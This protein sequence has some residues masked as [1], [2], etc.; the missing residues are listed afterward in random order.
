MRTAGAPPALRSTA[1]YI[2]RGLLQVVDA[3]LKAL[4]SHELRPVRRPDIVRNAKDF[5]GAHLTADLSADDMARTLG[6][7]YRLLNYAFKYALGISPYQYIQTQK[8]HAVR[9]L[10]KS[11]DITVTEAC[12]THGFYTPS[13]FA[14]QFQTYRMGSVIELSR[15]SFH[16]VD[17]FCE[18]EISLGWEFEPHWI[19]YCRPDRLD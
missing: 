3:G 14:R 8:L 15:N 12:F 18:W 5:V 11:S 13:R 2:T 6:V 19:D 7:S 16:D 4:G 17:Q 10:L 1:T 9:W